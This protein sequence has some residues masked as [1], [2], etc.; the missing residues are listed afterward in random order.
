MMDNKKLY[1][2]VGSLKR[3]KAWMQ[4]LNAKKGGR[5]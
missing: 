3:L 4:K 2:Q 5:A 1:G